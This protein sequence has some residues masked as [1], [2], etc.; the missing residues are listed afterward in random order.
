VLILGSKPWIVRK[1]RLF[2]M[3]S[4]PDQFLKQC[5]FFIF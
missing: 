4:M 2:L 1:E 5:G 3:R